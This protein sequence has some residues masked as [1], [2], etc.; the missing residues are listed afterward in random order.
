MS[1][2]AQLELDDAT[3]LSLPGS[4]RKYTAQRGD[5][6]GNAKVSLG[7][8]INGES[9]RYQRMLTVGAWNYATVSTATTTTVLSGSGIIGRVYVAGGTMGN[10][11]IYDNTAASGTTVLPTT[12][13]VQGQELLRD[14]VVGTGFTIVT[15]AATILTIAY[16]S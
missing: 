2:I 8:L 4:P 13:V 6:S 11:T 3:A 5:S 1:L 12:T 15:S 14:V 7:T 10:V 9:S 16:I